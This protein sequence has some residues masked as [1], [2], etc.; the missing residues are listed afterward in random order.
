MALMRVLWMGFTHHKLLK[1]KATTPVVPGLLLKPAQHW[2]GMGHKG[3]LK[4][5]SHNPGIFIS[6]FI[7][8]VLSQKRLR[9]AMCGLFLKNIYS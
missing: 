1:T 6:S 8:A 5:Q 3:L 7:Q 4:I 9:K 2:D